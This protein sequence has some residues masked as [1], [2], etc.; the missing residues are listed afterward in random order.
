MNQK[1]ANYDVLWIISEICYYLGLVLAVL[2]I[3]VLTFALWAMSLAD[4]LDPNYWYVLI[5]W[6]LSALVFLAG[7]VLKNFIYSAKNKQNEM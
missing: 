4:K 2:F 1:P 6:V 3:P 7:V 5:A